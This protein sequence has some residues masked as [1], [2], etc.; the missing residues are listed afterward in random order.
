MVRGSLARR[1]CWSVPGPSPQRYCPKINS[2]DFRFC[3]P[4]G[5]WMAHSQS[6]GQSSASIFGPPVTITGTLIFL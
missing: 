6:I 5:L 4:S 2:E 3:G 1:P